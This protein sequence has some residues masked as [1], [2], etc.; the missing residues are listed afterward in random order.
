[1]YTEKNIP[2][3]EFSLNRMFRYI[4]RIYDSILIQEN[5]SHRKLVFS[6]ILRSHGFI[7]VLFFSTVSTSFCLSYICE[8][9]P[10]WTNY[11]N[12]FC[13]SLL[14]HS[15][16]FFQVLLRFNIPPLDLKHLLPDLVAKF[17]F[18]AD[19]RSYL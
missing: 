9:L 4:D 1:M 5:T 17:F 10:L 19:P 7:H 16:S 13:S 14:Q 11:P 2:E 12:Y 3:H 18:W 8:M 6:H 15:P